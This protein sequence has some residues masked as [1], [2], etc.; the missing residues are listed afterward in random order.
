MW[1]SVRYEGGCAASSLRTTTDFC[2]S[3]EHL[4]AWRDDRSP[5]G[6]GFR[7]SIDEGLEAGRALFGPSLAALDT[8]SKSTAV[9]RASPNCPA[10]LGKLASHHSEE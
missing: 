5:D 7:L 10:A 6:P 4:S 1:Q 3:H 8:A 2:C 9:A